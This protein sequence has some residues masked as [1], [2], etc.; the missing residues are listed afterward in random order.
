MGRLKLIGW[1]RERC[2]G[3]AGRDS[4]FWPNSSAF[5]QITPAACR[6]LWGGVPAESIIEHFGG[7]AIIHLLSGLVL[8]SIPRVVRGVRLDRLAL[9]HWCVQGGGVGWGGGSSIRNTVQELVHAA[10]AVPSPLPLLSPPHLTMW[11]E[12]PRRG[13]RVTDKVL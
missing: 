4:L 7:F 12:S 1:S 3:R 6:C 11:A 10:E 13:E 5:G 9:P 8:G 2:Q